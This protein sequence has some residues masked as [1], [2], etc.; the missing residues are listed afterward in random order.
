M[1]LYANY[2]PD[3]LLLEILAVIQKWDIRSKQPTLYRFCA[4]NRY[5]ISNLIHAPHV[6]MFYPRLTSTD[7]GTM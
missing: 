2:L 6:M 3:E 5:I 4:V 1:P 7:S